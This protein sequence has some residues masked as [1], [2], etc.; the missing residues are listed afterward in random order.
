MK[1]EEGGRRKVKRGK[2]RTE[3]VEMRNDTERRATSAERSDGR[4]KPVTEEEE[5]R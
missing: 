3:W 5:T 1:M 4:H 2:A